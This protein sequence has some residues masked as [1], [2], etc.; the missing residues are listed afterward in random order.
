M[1][2]LASTPRGVREPCA[3]LCLCLSLCDVRASLA[4]LRPACLVPCVAH[5]K[6]MVTHRSLRQPLR[7]KHAESLIFWTVCV[8]AVMRS[9]S[10]LNLFIG[11]R[12]GGAADGGA[13]AKYMLVSCMLTRRLPAPGHSPAGSGPS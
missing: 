7:I 12:A 9:A 8:S 2:T 13:L 6:T 10:D 5:L 11:L 1:C 3:R 4:P